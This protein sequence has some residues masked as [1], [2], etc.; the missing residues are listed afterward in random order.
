MAAEVGTVEAL[1]RYPVKSMLGEQLAATGVGERGVA[2]DR[3]YALVDAET[4]LVASA[5]NPRR[6]G[7]LFACSAR[8]LEEPDPDGDPPPVA[9]TFGNGRTV[10]SDAR[11]A[12][13]VL[14][15][16]VGRHVR[17]ATR[18]PDAPALEELWP[19]VEGVAPEQRE[20]VTREQIALLA[21]PGTFFDAAPV[22]LVSST[23]LGS[24]R[25]ARPAGD[26]DARRFRPNVVVASSGEGFP[27]NDWVGATLRVGG[28]VE[29]QIVLAVPRCVMT[30]LAQGEL[31]A[32]KSI[33]QTVS[34][35]NRIDIPGL[36]P[37]SCLGA[38][39]LVT[40]AG[41]IAGG[42]PAALG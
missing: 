2:G 10:R 7:M 8:F 23:S 14:S 38:Y 17:L 3:A 4:G 29:L 34:R 30:T 25:R 35:Q 9:I 1:W 19:D 6:W 13:E 33:L 39:G 32:D 26:F 11:E 37:S 21:P 27:E 31:P 20:T 5:K 24:L 42:D 40:T 12:D 41:T 22:H 36:G 16:F 28:D 18:A 15:A